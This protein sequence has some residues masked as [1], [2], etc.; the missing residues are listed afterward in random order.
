M[1]LDVKK[2]R[3]DFPILGTKL[4]YLDNATTTHKPKQIICEEYNFY[5]KQYSSVYRSVYSLSSLITNKIENIRNNIAHFINASSYKE[6]IFVKGTTEAI[7]LIANS[8]GE[9]NLNKG[10]NIIISYME[11]HSNILPW[12]MLACRKQL[13]LKWIPM[14]K[15]GNLKLKNLYNI[16][17]KNTKLVAITH[18]SNVLGT[19]N[20][21]KQLIQFIK[22]INNN[23]YVLIDGA[24]AIS[25]IKIDVINLNCDFY[26]FSGHKIY[27]PTGIG[28]LYVKQSILNNMIPW[29]VGG[30]IVDQVELSDTMKITYTKIPWMF[31]PGTPNISGI[32]GLGKAIQYIQ[33]IGINNITHYEK[34]LT[35]Y[36]LTQLKNINQIIIYG[37]KEINKRVGIISFN[38][39]NIHSYDIAN[40]LDNYDINI[41]TGHLCAIPL[42]KF[43]NVSSMCR[44]SL[45][46]YNYKEE[47]DIFINKLNSIVINLI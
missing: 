32:I 6:I 5:T 27:G 38:I 17:N 3:Q 41:R 35:K 43:Y 23:I 31:E 24:Q 8:W 22:S 42:M 40:L 2:I 45:G 28:I 37:P 36:L 25:R 46:I 21:I 47:I 4:I 19:I 30:G 11:H 15:K 39:P 7:N 18:V 29:Q 1:I 20:P 26:V 16:I 34:Q 13:I 10:D 44:V 12:Y 9:I 33:N 14:T